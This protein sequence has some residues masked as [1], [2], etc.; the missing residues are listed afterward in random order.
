MGTEKT[1]L[2]KVD[3][4]VIANLDA[5]A[6]E[7]GSLALNTGATFEKTLKTA[8]LMQRIRGE[9]TKPG[10]MD[11]VVSLQGSAVGFKADRPNSKNP[12]PYS[13]AELVDPCIE[14]VMRG[15]SLVGNEMNVIS[16]NC[17]ATK[18]GLARK[19]REMA[20]L[21]NVRIVPGL[22]RMQSGG[23]VIDMEVSW[24]YKNTDGK[25][26][27]TFAVRVNEGQGA[28][29]IIGKATRKARAWLIGYLT[30][31]EMPEGE[32]GEDASLAGAKNV[33]AEVDAATASRLAGTG[34]KAEP[35]KP[36]A[37]SPASA[38]CN[39]QGELITA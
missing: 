35:E 22:P 31:S 12:T 17:Y 39:E 2:I 20:E 30:G 3:Q 11:A 7:A 21:R 24:T 10:V 4:T 13:A 34:K 23:A 18:E 5:C 33:T 1:S 27:L 36:A 8:A 32:V 19:I 9:L 15:L 25:E 6:Q 37:T 28:D 38:P 14:A 16:K 29:A 26:K